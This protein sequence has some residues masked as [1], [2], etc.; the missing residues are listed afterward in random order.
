MEYLVLRV[1]IAKVKSKVSADILQV[2]RKNGEEER[3]EKE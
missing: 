3:K 2:S 1:A